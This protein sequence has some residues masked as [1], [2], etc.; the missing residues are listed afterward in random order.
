[1]KQLLVK[2]F[3]IAAFAIC[4]VPGTLLAQ[5]KEKEKEKTKEKTE[6]QQIVITRT[7]DK[8]DKMVIEIN[9][10]KVKVN[11]KDVA[12]LK[13]VQV[14]VNNLRVPRGM[15]FHTSPDGFGNFNMSF[16]DASGGL[17]KID[18]NRAML[19]VVTDGD[20]K[21]AEIQSVSKE[22]AAEKAGL[23]KGDIITKIDSKKIDETNDVSDAVR[24]HKPGE[25]VSITYLRDGKEQKTTAELGRWKGMDMKTMTMP[26]VFSQVQ[27][28][29]N[30]DLNNRIYGRVAPA[31]PGT[32]T[33][34]ILTD[35][36]KLGLSIQD[37]DDG[38]G[39]KVL[40]VD[41]EGTAAKAGV[42][43]GDVI[44]MIDD[45]AVNSTDDITRLIREK[46]DQPTVKMQVARGGKTQTLEVRVKKAKTVDL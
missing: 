43:E 36:P 35:R 2:H 27:G 29:W 8:A 44:T 3:V 38:K 34:R 22:S 5:D 25:K 33:Y 23:K 32:G 14:H 11:G 24:A 37:T 39:V 10:D 46:R 28:N 12:D 1:M 31:V 9:G 41:D 19:G 40:D 15:T 21:G 13:D 18:S 42:K 16:D 20:D 7:G 4:A 17:F 26:K 6:R 45:K 30:Q